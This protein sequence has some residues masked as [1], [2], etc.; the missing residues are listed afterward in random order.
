MTWYHSIASN[1][2]STYANSGLL[3]MT[4]G[5]LNYFSTEKTIASKSNH[6]KTY[7]VKSE[8][9]TSTDFFSPVIDLDKNPSAIAVQ[10]IIN[11][12][13]ATNTIAAAK[14]ATGSSDAS[15][16]YISRPITL[17]DGQDAE[18]FKIFITGYKPSG[19]D[20]KV[21]GRF[22]SADDPE[23]LEDKNYTLMTQITPAN[24][25]SSTTNTNDFREY[26]YGLTAGAN[27][28]GNTTAQSAYLYSGNNNV[29]SYHDNGGAQYHTF[30]TFNIKVVMTSNNS[31][32]IPRMT[33]LRAIAMQV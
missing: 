13:Y 27:A 11:D 4:V 19:S 21:F 5:G 24:V 33:D 15:A 7:F 26:E 18:D 30:K 31:V 9:Q 28:V 29:I 23:G 2:T 25:V 3:S 20:L 16:V 12:P 6:N 22:L 10:N 1:N 14:E 32:D 17:A 8:L